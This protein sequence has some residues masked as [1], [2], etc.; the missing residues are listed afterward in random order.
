MNRF[1]ST[2][3]ISAL[4]FTFIHVVLHSCKKP[5]KEFPYQSFFFCFFYFSFH[6]EN[7]GSHLRNARK[8]TSSAGKMSSLDNAQ[9][10]KEKNP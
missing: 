2:V 8:M 5:K 9:N 7:S 10:G 6:F 1:D 4:N 3:A